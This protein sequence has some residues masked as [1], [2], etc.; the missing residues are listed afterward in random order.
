MEL[1]RYANSVYGQSVLVGASW[2]LIWWCVGTGAA[3]IIVHA[4]MKA[5]LGGRADRSPGV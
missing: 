5:L 1:F 4:V 3:F 2:D